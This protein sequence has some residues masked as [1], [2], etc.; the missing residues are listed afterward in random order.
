MFTCW[1]LRVVGSILLQVRAFGHR[2]VA[3]PGRQSR[4]RAVGQG[5]RGGA[6]A[7][8]EGARR[9]LAQV[10]GVRVAVGAP[11]AVRRRPRQPQLGRV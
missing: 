1:D 5:G 8:V 4:A 9:G 10:A 3:A 6:A 11:V 2:G 7:A